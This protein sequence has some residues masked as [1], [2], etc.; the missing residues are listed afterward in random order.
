[1]IYIYI[2]RERERGRDYKH[3]VYVSCAL[4]LCYWWDPPC[5]IWHLADQAAC[6]IVERRPAKFPQKGRGPG[7]RAGPRGA[8]RLATIRQVQASIYIYIYIIYEN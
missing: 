6:I 3:V 7:A 4:G 5:E 1:L 8:G 2:Y